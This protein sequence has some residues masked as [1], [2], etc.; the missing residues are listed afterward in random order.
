MSEA[1]AASRI[2][3][4]GWRDPRLWVGVVLVAGSVV[5]GASVVGN[6]DDSVQVWALARDAGE[7]ERI[8]P[9]DLVATRVRLLDGS[10]ERYLGV[11][12]QLPSDLVLTRAVE[13]GEL[14]PGSALGDGDD[15]ALL[16]VSIAVSAERVPGGVTGG[17]RIDIWTVT[18]RDGAPRAELVLGEALV[19]EAPSG[20]ESFG[21]SGGMRQLVI[22]V[23]EDAAD[24]VGDLIAATDGDSIRVVARG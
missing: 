17:S 20:A 15:A 4:P 21:S 1:P 10:S 19:V 24:Q 8:S 18:E 22:G 23:P 7:G 5:L 2:Q 16:R 3:R 14:L 9:D 13:A 6:A 12:E 11:S